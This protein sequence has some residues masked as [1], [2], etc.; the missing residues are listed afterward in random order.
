MLVLKEKYKGNKL[1]LALQFKR[2]GIPEKF[3]FRDYKDQILVDQACSQ[4]DDGRWLVVFSRDIVLQFQF[5]SEILKCRPQQKPQFIDFASFILGLIGRYSKYDMLSDLESNLVS[6]AGI[7]FSNYYKENV[8]DF[9]V[10]LGKVF[11]RHNAS[12]I[13]G[14]Q[15]VPDNKLRATYGSEMIDFIENSNF[16]YFKL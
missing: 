8:G 3:W 12:I 11:A 10:Y 4:L 7:R 16:V 13:L 6:I 1:R 14:F 2:A 15:S 5:I 9:L